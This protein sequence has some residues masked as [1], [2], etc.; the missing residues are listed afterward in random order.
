MNAE[1]VRRYMPQIPRTAAIRLLTSERFA[2][3]MSD[4]LQLFAREYGVR[5]ELRVLPEKTIH[6]RHLVIDSDAVYQSG[7]SFKDGARNAPTSI[8]QIVDIAR[9]M[10]A[11]HEARWASAR[12][13]E[14]K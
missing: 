8:N 2:D 6:D 5:A 13:V 3:Q 10:I 11:A 14:I 1:F 9:E 7:A 4:A 12:D